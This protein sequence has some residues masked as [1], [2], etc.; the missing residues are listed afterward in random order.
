ML[1]LVI[2]KRGTENDKLYYHPI[3]ASDMG[4]KILQLIPK[5][6]CVVHYSNIRISYLLMNSLLIFLEEAV[7]L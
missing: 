3:E 1:G 7:L 6:S 2:I 5:C 4:L